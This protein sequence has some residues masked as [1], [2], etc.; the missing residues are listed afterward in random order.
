LL[1]RRVAARL[2]L[3]ALSIAAVPSLLS[4]QNG[5]IPLTVEKIYGHGPLIGHLP[6]DVTWSPD[7]KHLTWLDGGQLIELDPASGKAHV[8]LSRAK[9]NAIGLSGGSEQDRDRRRRYN[10]PS[11]FWSPDDNH[12]LFNANGRLWLF[13]L[14]NSTGIQVAF[15][16]N[17]VGADPKFSPNGEALSFVRDHTL[18]VV[19]LR[20]PSNPMSLIGGNLPEGVLNGEVDWVYQ[21]ELDVRS[22]QF[23]SPDSKN[24][25]YLQ[26]NESLVPDYP[27]VD[28]LPVHAKVTAQR[29]PQP[30][31]LN[32][33]VRVGV[34]SASGGRTTWMHIPLRN[35]HD[36]I[37]RFGWADRRTLWVETLTRDHK[38]RYIYLADPNSGQTHLVLELSDEKFLDENYDIAVDDGHIILTNWSDGHNHIYLYAYDPRHSGNAATLQKQLTK[39]DFEV[40]GVELIDWGRKLVNY[41]SNQGN[42]L[43]Q[44]LWQVT[45]DGQSTALTTTPGFHDGNFGGE[46]GA[47]VDTFSTRITPPELSLCRQAGTCKSFWSTHALDPY[48]LR[49][50]EQLEAKAAD[51]TTLYETLMLPEGATAPKS[52]PLIVNPY[53]GPGAQTVIDRW[54]ENLWADNLLVDELFAQHGFAVLRADNRGMGNRGRAFAQA[55]YHD[56]GAVQL[57]DQLAVLDQV[58]EKYPQLDPQR[59]GWWG[60]SWGGHFTLYAMTHSDR[61]RAGVA[62][63]PVTDWHDYDSIYTERYLGLP[64]E[65]AAAYKDFSA[66]NSAGQLKGR[67]L[68]LHGTSDDNVHIQ[69]SIQ[70]IQQLIDAH[71]PYDFQVFPGKTHS[72]SGREARVALFTRILAHFE[73]YLKLQDNS[74]PE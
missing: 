23:W 72:I 17:P 52:V 69:N 24:I 39:G 11:Y 1:L 47:F 19:R 63:A 68:L 50:P 26:M 27:L 40:T 16:D 53:G 8:L 56:F 65:D 25:A 9:L 57:N 28:F 29:Y 44:Q 30:E 66:V 10:L 20:E 35:G 37:P 59:L 61:F 55:A 71:I 70:F 14:T 45:F 4:A 43:Q 32:P 18:S 6:A 2:L 48:H 64:S 36:Y 60:W 46:G 31:D 41:A 21:E 54:G 42:V 22:N 7:G 74:S 33:D 12:I 13:D 49:A 67:L 51:G 5:A 73:R 62:V 58:L 3:I 38:H 15:T 34:V